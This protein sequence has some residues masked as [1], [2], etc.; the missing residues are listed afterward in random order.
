MPPKLPSVALHIG[1]HK[2]ATSHLQKV[3]YNNR[4]YLSEEG[5]RCYGPGYLRQKGRS[6]AD[7]FGMSWSEGAA[8]KRN[9]QDQLHFLTKGRTRLVFTE[10][11]FV[12]TLS[13]KY[14]RISLPIYPNGVARVTE[15]VA[16]WG[17]VKPRVFLAVRNPAT[18][19]ASAYSQGLLEGAHIGPRTFRA[20]NDWRKVDWVEYV[21]GLRDIDGIG[22]IFVWRQEDYDRCHRLILRR[23]LRWKVG[24][25]VQTVKGRVNPG[26]SAA[27]VRQTLQWAQDGET[28][29]LAGKARRRFPVNEDNKPFSLYAPPTLAA[30][31]DIYDV[32]MAQI[33]VLD[34]VTVLHP[35]GPRAQG[36]KSSD[37]TDT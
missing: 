32:Q 22:K 11:N 30:A 14:G 12:G 24:P 31:Q 18:Y 20:R 15:L 3:L 2:T 13:D 29:K 35:R 33:E 26:L 16:A 34:G 9:P 27:A 25:K 37:K 5:I 36:L 8:P 21:T 28:G 7:L 23:L 17:S 19:M 6:L 1:A 4:A 10:E